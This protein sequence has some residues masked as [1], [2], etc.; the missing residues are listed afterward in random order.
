MVVGIRMWISFGV[1][2]QSTTGHR[3]E[4]RSVVARGW[5]ERR[6]EFIM[7]WTRAVVVDSCLYNRQNP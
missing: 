6:I 2:I 7:G 3:M 4:S 5:G 1:I